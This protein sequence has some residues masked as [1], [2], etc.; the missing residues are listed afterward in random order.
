MDMPRKL[1]C[2][3][4]SV[5]YGPSLAQTLPR[6]VALF[7]EFVV[8]TTAQ[9]AATQ[10]IARQHGARVVVSNRCYDGDHAFNKGR[11]IN[12]GLAVLTDP[13]WIVLT[14]A[15]I[16]LN[17]GTRAV[18]LA[19][20]LDPACLYFTT[21]EEKAPV[22]GQL[23]SIN[24]EP[25]GYFQLFNRLA[26]QV[27]G[28]WPNPMCEEFCSA[29]GIDSWFFQQWP[30]S[31]LMPIVEVGVQHLSS[32]HWGQNWNGIRARPGTW[33]Q[34]GVL[35]MMGFSSIVPTKAV[36]SV[37]RLTDTRFGQSV[38]IETKNLSAYVRRVPSGLEFMGRELGP[39][40][41]HVAHK[42]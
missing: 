38:T 31:Q 25:N 8:V 26:G 39:Y 11:M 24:L 14:D 29:G 41:I 5:D 42:I 23:P 7:D 20:K 16:F 12:D 22:S 9:D 21:R 3:T 40:H 15:D 17:A 32:R 28:K 27:R 10:S 2:V 4:V 35:T 13:D 34:F 36:P 18:L 19:M 1:S 37:I 6:N 33:C 30:Q